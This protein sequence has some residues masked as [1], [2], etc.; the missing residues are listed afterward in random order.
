MDEMVAA[1]DM[2]VDGEPCVPVRA[3]SELLFHK[4][5]RDPAFPATTTEFLLA[6]QVECSDGRLGLFSDKGF[7]RQFLTCIAAEHARSS[8]GMLTF[9]VFDTIVLRSEKCEP[10]RFWEIAHRQ[11]EALHSYGRKSGVAGED[12]FVARLMATR[13]SYRLRTPVEG[14][15]EGSIRDIYRCVALTVGLDAQFIEL[16]LQIELD[17]EVE[18]LTPN[19]LALE[20]AMFAKAN[21]MVTGLISDM[22]L[23]AEHIESILAGVLGRD[24][25]LFGTL[26]SSAD[27]VV[28]K[29]SGKLF[30]RL[31]TADGLEPRAHLH[32]GDNVRT[33]YKMPRSRGWRSYL[34]PIPF[35]ERA[36]IEEDYHHFVEELSRRGLDLGD[37][38]KPGV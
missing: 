19:P 16:L 30:D 28:S 26:T 31:A 10:R 4:G 15:R 3:R 12:L 11:A 34:L 14:C 33:D 6:R 2:V 8:I 25:S 7:Q 29:G 24:R 23:H 5:K 1:I 9:D 37:W 17:Y 22:Y 21:G 36:T 38:I 32:V 13:A 35:K 20:L 18:N 27:T